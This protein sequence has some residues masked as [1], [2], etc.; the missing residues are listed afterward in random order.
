VRT[1]RPLP[2]VPCYIFPR[3]APHTNPAASNTCTLTYGTTHQTIDG[4]GIGFVEFYSFEYDNVYPILAIEDQSLS[5]TTSLAG[6]MTL[7][8]SDE[9]A[10]VLTTYKCTTT[11]SLVQEQP[12]GSRVGS[13]SPIVFPPFAS[14][15]TA[16]NMLYGAV[17]FFNTIAGVGT[18]TVTDSLGQ[19]WNTDKN[20]DMATAGASVWIFSFPNTAAGQCVVT[21]TASGS[22]GGISAIFREYS[23]PN[24]VTPLDKSPS[25]NSTGT[26]LSSGLSGTLSQATEL[27]ICAG[28]VAQNAGTESLAVGSGFG[29][30]ASPSYQWLQTI[31]SAQ[32]NMLFSPTSGI[33]LS[34]VRVGIKPTSYAST[35]PATGF[36]YDVKAA[37]A[38]GAT[39]I[40]ASNWSPP[41]TWKSGGAFGGG[42]L[43]AIHY[44]DYANY[45]AS[46]VTWAAS[47]GVNI[48]AI[49]PQNE[50]DFTSADFA[51]GY[52]AA[53]MDSF[54][55]VL[56]PI[57]TTTKIIMPEEAAWDFSIASTVWGDSNASYVGITAAH[58]YSGTI[59]AP[60]GPG[61][62]NVWA[63]EYAHFGAY[64]ASMTDGMTC[65]T[66]W[67][68]L[69]VTA[70]A[71][72]I[73]YWEPW[74]NGN[75]DNEGL[76]SDPLVSS[77][78]PKRYYVLG[79]WSKF[80]KPGWLRIDESDSGWGLCSAYRDPGGYQVA[81]VAIN[82]TG[83]SI[84]VTFTI[85]G[86]NPLLSSV[87]PYITDASNNLAIQSTIGVSSGVFTAT[88][89]ANSVTTFLGSVSLEPISTP[90]RALPPAL[91]AI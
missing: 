7:S 47:Q 50:P 51:C 54:F 25:A 78:Q 2:Y 56:G 75:S 40:V 87:T 55:T 29:N 88:L 44:T 91:L 80:V 83:S 73:L 9:W 74:N 32:A 43:S 72:A 86:A 66:D 37:Q 39:R 8:T 48:Y 33:G 38:S 3:Y 6:T 65:A 45:L 60:G 58:N 77:T 90:F 81:V 10:C 21:I 70:G 23:G 68:N 36:I 34:I 20:Q 67:H 85:S 64:D 11:P 71:S 19:T 41:A 13:L 35:T 12:V 62:A 63:T 5:A 4:F 22:F 61:G 52:T 15:V 16:G 82:N 27:A 24:T 17:T 79:N 28:R 42:S 89:N 18:V 53:Q 1:Y 49:S 14:N 76:M 69:M 26:A 46:Y 31:T 30:F 59:S 57:L 84:S